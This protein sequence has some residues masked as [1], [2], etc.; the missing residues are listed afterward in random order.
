MT[1]MP[2]SR[3]RA[4]FAVASVVVALAPSASYA[5]PEPDLAPPVGEAVSQELA[6]LVGN[7]AMYD[8]S[9]IT[10]CMYDDPEPLAY[11][12]RQIVLRAD[13]TPAVAVA[14]VNAAINAVGSPGQATTAKVIKLPGIP[15]SPW[16]EV[17][18]QTR[19]LVVS[20]KPGQG[21]N[22]EVHIVAV[23][24]ELREQDII[25][26][27][28]YLMSPTD[29]PL[30]VW[31]DGYPENT[32]LRTDPRAGHGGGVDVYVYDTGLAPAQIERPPNITE[33]QPGVDQEI[34]DAE[35]RAG[36]VDRYYAN[37][38][39]SIAD[40]FATLAPDAVLHAVKI[41]NSK[42][43]VTDV[44]AT[45]RISN[46]LRNPAPDPEVIV[47]SF[48]SPG[49]AVSELASD[50]DMVPLGLEAIAEAVEARN[51][52]VVVA[53]AGNRTSDLAF[54]PGAFDTVGNPEFDAVIGIG[55]LDVVAADAS[56]EDDPWASESRSGPIADFSNFGS[57]VD[58]WA[59]GV[60]LPVRHIDGL[61]FRKGLADITGWAT[62]N[63]T[64]YAAPYVG[65][66]I[67]E[68]MNTSGK[69][70]PQAWRD[71]YRSG[72]E[73]SVGGMAL[74]LTDMSATATT[75]TALPPEC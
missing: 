56:P 52:S 30:G 54:Y 55:A 39:G 12:T 68:H 36:V 16:R 58:V 59:P 53:A 13:L 70:A 28:N 65:A 17:E 74:A 66:L 46:T 1:R 8:D 75:T 64:S 18:E 11:S 47:E 33:L 69:S 29:G 35:P 50:G 40:V 22:P 51:R 44:T 6:D 71:V 34:L 27:P 42:G 24:R 26:S 21:E 45:T 37:H 7:G 31:P 15:P 3:R 4:L 63:G 19:L 60:G 49:C 25:A 57:A 14:N 38:T 72:N 61:R 32:A 10:D 9:L 2:A 41:T 67:A 20:L 48:G 43:I 5:A 62:V 73:C 23:A